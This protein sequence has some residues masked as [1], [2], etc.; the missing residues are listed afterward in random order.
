[1]FKNFCLSCLL[2]LPNALKAET[3]ELY[4]QAI[5][6]LFQYD[7]QG[8]YDQIIQLATPEQHSIS[9][10]VLPN[11]RASN[12]FQ[13]CINCCLS[14]ANLNPNFYSFGKEVTATQPLNSAKAYI[15]SLTEDEVYTELTQLVGKRV[16]LERGMNYGKAVAAGNFTHSVT[17]S[18]LQNFKMLAIHRI[19]TMIAYA[20]DIYQAFKEV[21]PN[22]FH[23]D[24]MQ[25]IAIHNDALVCRGVEPS[26][27]K[28]FN[29]KLEALR[30]TGKLKE[31]LGEL[32][33]AP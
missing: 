23:Y 30:N 22:R 9:L 12:E 24:E 29:T 20:P 16:G 6:G 13:T 21:D 7:N 14:P 28:G 15:F 1:M 33:V 2:V 32:Y 10:Q 26:F 19:D 25:P 31:V 27:I 18:L 4:V 8:V 11:Y 5:P 3:I 17:N